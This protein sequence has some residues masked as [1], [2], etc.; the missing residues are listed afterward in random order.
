MYVFTKKYKKGLNFSRPAPGD[1]GGGDL[2]RSENFWLRLTTASAQ[3]L[4]RLWAFFHLVV[5]C[6]FVCCCSAFSMSVFL[7]FN[8][9][10]RSIAMNPDWREREREREKKNY[11]QLRCRHTRRAISPSKLVP[12]LSNTYNEQ[13]TKEN[14][15]RQR[16]NR[17][18]GKKT[19]KWKKNKFWN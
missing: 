14:I 13:Y 12:I 5:V 4:R 16:R 7:S 3:C 19:N 1:G 6:L 8:R 17:Q 18:Y 15:H 2:R 11:S 9:L 10:T